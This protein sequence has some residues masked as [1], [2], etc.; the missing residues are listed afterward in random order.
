MFSAAVAEQVF[1]F[2]VM[3]SL[4]YKR[5]SNGFV[6]EKYSLLGSS[7]SNG[8]CFFGKTSSKKVADYTFFLFPVSAMLSLAAASPRELLSQHRLV[9]NDDPCDGTC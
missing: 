2:L 8:D 6:V 1:L 5:L 9:M 3:L 4:P 7:A